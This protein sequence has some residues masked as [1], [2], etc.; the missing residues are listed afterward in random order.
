VSVHRNAMKNYSFLYL[1]QRK[2]V[3][4]SCMSVCLS[5]CLSVSLST[6][7]LRK[8]GTYVDDIVWRCGPWHK[9]NQL[10]VHAGNVMLV[11]TF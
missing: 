2:E 8:F 4:S 1:R 10:D 7:L 3:M 5:V 9:E 11:N 6:R